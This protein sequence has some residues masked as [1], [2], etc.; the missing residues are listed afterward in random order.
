MQTYSQTTGSTVLLDNNLDLDIFRSGYTN[1]RFRVE[2]DSVITITSRHEANLPGLAY[3]YY[4]DTEMWRAIVA[5]NGIENPIDD[6]I[7]GVQ[8]LMPDRNSMDAVLSGDRNQL[9]GRIIL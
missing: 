2:V 3:D 9:P 5:F 6:V 8:L 7:V 1:L 4:G